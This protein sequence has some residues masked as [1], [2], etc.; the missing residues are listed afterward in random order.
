MVC[1]RDTHLSVC[2][3]VCLCVS[4]VA[5]AWTH[6]LVKEWPL[7]LYPTTG[8]LTA[9]HILHKEARCAHQ[10]A[11][12]RFRTRFPALETCRPILH[13]YAAGLQ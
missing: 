3:S 7:V 1:V 8:W 6:R 12:C 10:A 11:S 5:Q 13:W 2:L 4:H 9:A